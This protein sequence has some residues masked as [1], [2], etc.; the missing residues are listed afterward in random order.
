MN[1]AGTINLV[2]DTIS[3][4]D[5]TLAGGGVISLLGIIPPVL[6]VTSVRNTIIA[7]NNDL[8]ATNILGRDVVGVLGSFSSLGNNLIGSNFGA[9]ANF[10]ASAFV[11]VTPQ[12]NANLDLVGN[13]TVGNQVID[14]LLGALQNNGGSTNTRAITAL[15]PA[16]NRGSSCITNNTCSSGL[17]VSL[18]T[19]QRNTGFS[20]FSGAA[21][22]IGAYELH[23]SNILNRKSQRTGNDLERTRCWRYGY[24]IDRCQRVFQSSNNY[25][26]R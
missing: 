20:R 22:D 13:V 10:T 7:N 5:S 25:A 17:S 11:G 19:D 23:G 2:N 16:F 3:Y 1:A 24:N 6:G 21:V 9:E 18:A 15:S 12:P 4:N 26:A 14:P 8:L